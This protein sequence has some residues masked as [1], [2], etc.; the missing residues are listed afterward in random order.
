MILFLATALGVLIAGIIALPAVFLEWNHRVKNAPL[1][2]DVDVWRGAKLTNR[3]AFAFG[4]LLHLLMGGLYGFCY[5]LFASQGWLLLTQAPYALHSMLL[6]SV[7]VWLVL[8]MIFFPLLGFG[9][10]G[11]KEGKTVW[12]E[13]LMSLVLEGAILWLVVQWYKPFFFG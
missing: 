8:G 2:I 1:I 11:I 7:G 6:F 3:E 13:A 12:M 5:A 10:F 4:I 9:W